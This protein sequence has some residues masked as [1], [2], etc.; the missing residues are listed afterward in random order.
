MSF[1][2]WIAKWTLTSFYAKRTQWRSR[3]SCVVGPAWHCPGQL[4]GAVGVTD[5]ARSPSESDTH[6][7]SPKAE[8][9]W[10]QLWWLQPP[11]GVGDYWWSQQIFIKFKCVQGTMWGEWK[12][13]WH[14]KDE[15]FTDA[16]GPESEIQKN[17]PHLNMYI[18]MHTYTSSVCIRGTLQDILGYEKTN[19]H[20][21]LGS[22]G[23]FLQGNR[24]DWEPNLIPSK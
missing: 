9:G 16:L 13:I 2:P 23:H 1:M 10:E 15:W 4:S 11:P 18:H 3:W 8:W 7:Y 21:G 14:W 24:R 17:D 22:W 6:P 12:W 20:N 5:I 19:L